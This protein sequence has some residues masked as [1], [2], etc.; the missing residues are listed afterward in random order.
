VHF[1]CNQSTTDQIFCI[2]Q[3]QVNKWEYNGTVH[4]LSVVLKKNYD[5]VRRQVLYN[6]V[7]EFGVTMKLDRLI[8]MCLNETYTEVLRGKHLS[9]SYSAY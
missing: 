7:T 8:K 4:Q 1:L 6:T 3:I 2:C 9:Y 5:S